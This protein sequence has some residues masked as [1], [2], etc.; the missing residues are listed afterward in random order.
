MDVQRMRLPERAEA[1]RP[2]VRRP[3]L[4]QQHQSRLQTLATANRG[5][6]VGKVADSAADHAKIVVDLEKEIS[7]LKSEASRLKGKMRS[8]IAESRTGRS[9]W[10]F[11]PWS[12]PSTGGTYRFDGGFQRTHRCPV[13]LDCTSSTRKL[14]SRG[15]QWCRRGLQLASVG[16]NLVHLIAYNVQPPV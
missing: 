9:D 5:D 11:A 7:R 15:R 14:V 13:L 3:A 4:C 1:D 6:P 12:S 8:S 16:C 10:R 2:T